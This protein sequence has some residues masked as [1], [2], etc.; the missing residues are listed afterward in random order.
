M[1]QAAQDPSLPT[2]TYFPLHAKA[3][4]IRMMLTHKGVAYNNVTVTFAEWPAL[5]ATLPSGQIPTW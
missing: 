1:A 4:P 2:L 5:K 3:C